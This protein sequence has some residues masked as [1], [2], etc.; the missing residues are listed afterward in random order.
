M[1]CALASKVHKIS[2]PEIFSQPDRFSHIVFHVPSVTQHGQCRLND[3]QRLLQETLGKQILKTLYFP[4]TIPQVTVKAAYPTFFHL[5]R[6]KK[7]EKKKR[8]HTSGNIQLNIVFALGA[9][10]NF[11]VKLGQ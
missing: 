9:P 7:L 3:K 11:I 1:E 2:K 5:K 10:A 8:S 4:L 6:Q